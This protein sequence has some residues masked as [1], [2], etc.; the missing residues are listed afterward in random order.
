M[1]TPKRVVRRYYFIQDRWPRGVWCT[2]GNAVLTMHEARDAA[3]ELADG[4]GFGSIVRVVR[5]TAEVVLRITNKGKRVRVTVEPVKGKV[6][7]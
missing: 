7:K 1:K 3:R 2:R 5:Q 6:R 4:Q